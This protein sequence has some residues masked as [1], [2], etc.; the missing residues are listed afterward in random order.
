MYANK[1]TMILAFYNS[2]DILQ[3]CSDNVHHTKRG[4]TFKTA[5]LV[6]NNRMAS[7][8]EAESSFDD[9][10]AGVGAVSSLNSVVS[11]ATGHSSKQGAA[12]QEF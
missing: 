3:E 1:N 5:P 6:V 12:F 7:A 2:P 4:S 11:H 10:L 9:E 8:Q